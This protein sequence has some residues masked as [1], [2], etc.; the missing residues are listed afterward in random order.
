MKL[1]KPFL[2]L[3]LAASLALTSC[4]GVPHGT[5]GNGTNKVSFVLVADT[6]PSNLGL[7]SFRITVNSV[8]LTSTT[9][10]NTTLTINGGSGVTVDL[11]RAQSDSAFLGTLTNVE[12]GGISSITVSLANA[13]VAF[14]NGTGATITNLS[15]QCLANTVCSAALSGTG[16]PVI[17]QSESV[18]GNT[19]FGI[20]FNL[21][22]A[23]SVKA[24][25]LTLNLTNST[26]N[27]SLN[28]VRAFALPRANSNLATG[29]L[30]LIEDFTGVV[31]VSGSSVTIASSGNV[32]RGSLKGTVNTSTALDT[33]PSGTLCKSPTPG[34]AS[35]CVANSQVASMDALLNS[36]GTFTVQELEPLLATPVVDTIEGT[37]VSINSGNQTQFGVI[38]TDLF[39][40]ASNSL[41]GSLRIGAPLTVNLAANVKTFQVDTKGLQV[42]AGFPNNF[43]FFSGAT[44]TTALH[45]G[46]NV[47]V[48][49][50]TFTAAN[51]ATAA[52]ANTD[53]V[54]L[55]W[56]RFISTVSIASAPQFTVT[57][58]PAQFG[59]TGASTFQ[60][61]TFGGTQGTEGVT[62]LDGIT[63]GA[64][65]AQ[66][67]AVAVRALFIE[68]AGNTLTP[69]FFAA[70]VRQH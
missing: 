9:G 42:A 62:N 52:S 70:K 17:T 38:V 69:A 18:N 6:V 3:G 21:A 65:L 13:E 61:Q 16:T 33:D 39:P 45:L 47:A 63:S 44:N 57:A 50:T 23:L 26:T 32:G 20:D 58:L 68:N 49:V 48:H 8:T 37:V 24:G 10:T 4:S 30:D 7:I 25:A 64:S 19:G 67:S 55:R 14:F 40:A 36:D 1:S 29:Q 31:A 12:T 22:N 35:S 66:G 53:T 54:T 51:G 15:P 43:G 5:N 34:N 59:V 11:V 60:V 27:T 2:S 56:S 28:V 46:Q 41:I